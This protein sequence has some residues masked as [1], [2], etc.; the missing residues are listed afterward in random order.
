VHNQQQQQARRRKSYFFA[1]FQ[2]SAFVSAL[3]K[4]INDDDDGNFTRL[5]ERE[6]DQ[7]GEG[8]TRNEKGL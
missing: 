3:N 8:E 1:G 5:R 2:F 6:I 7:S 4:P